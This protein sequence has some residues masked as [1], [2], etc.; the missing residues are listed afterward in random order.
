M[1]KS[2]EEYAF[3][4]LFWQ[5]IAT[6]VSGFFAVFLIGEGFVAVLL[7]MT[8][9]GTWLHPIMYGKWRTRA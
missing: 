8:F 2:E 9:I 7:Y 5:I 6:P 3:E 4:F 1:K